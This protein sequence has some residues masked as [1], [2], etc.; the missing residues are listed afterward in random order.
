MELKSNEPKA[1]EEFRRGL[2]EIYSKD[3][4]FELVDEDTIKDLNEKLKKQQM[5]GCDETRC[6]QEISN[7]FGADEIITGE[8]K[9]LANQYFLTL[10][11]TKRDADTF[12]V[13]IKSNLQKSFFE[14]QKSYYIKEIAKYE[15]V[16][17]K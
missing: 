3:S 4:K 6:L 1:A 14:K 9:V 13:G 7:S 15:I 11:V 8:L 17:K 10:K 16:K 5:L 2:K 12:E